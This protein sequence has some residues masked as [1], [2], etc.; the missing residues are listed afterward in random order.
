MSLKADFQLISGASQGLNLLAKALFFAGQIESAEKIFQQ[1]ADLELASP[2]LQNCWGGPLNGQSG[3]QAAVDDLLRILD[4]VT[5][6]ETG[7]FRGITT[8]WFAE[9]YGG[10]V[11]TCEKEKLYYLQA[12]VRLANFRNVTLR[13]QDSRLFL[14]EILPTLPKEGI[15]MFYLDAHWDFD[16]PL[17]EELEVIFRCRS[18]AVVLID[19]FKVPDDPGYGWD[20]YGEGK[21]LTTELLPGVVPSHSTVFFPTLP[22]GAESGAARGYCLIA[23]EAAAK[24]AESEFLRGDSLEKWIGLE[25]RSAETAANGDMRE[26]GEI[27]YLSQPINKRIATEVEDLR[28]SNAERLGVISGLAAEVEDLRRSNAERLGVITGL[29][30]EVEEL[31]HSNPEWL[32]GDRMP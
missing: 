31:R 2:E 16:L 4:P 11:L 18:D 20:D 12:K 7:T 19:D 8:A 27:A 10:P 5:V 23:S 9:R 6:V 22:S 24:V 13:R 30:A 25:K 29:A 15:V 14:R 28:R 21:S 3:R 1:A 32:E 26:P 17:K